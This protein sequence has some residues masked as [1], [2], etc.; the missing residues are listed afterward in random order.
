MK[1]SK[2]IA[3]VMLAAVLALGTG[4][5]G[6]RG[7]GTSAPVQ[8]AEEGMLDLAEEAQ[9]AIIEEENEEGAGKN[10]KKGEKAGKITA[11]CY[12]DFNNISPEKEVQELF[13]TRFGGTVE[14]V[15][16]CNS[17]NYF[18]KLGEMVSTGD[19]PDIVRC[20]WT[21]QYGAFIDGKFEALDD[22]LDI[23]SPVWSDMNDIIESFACGGKHYYFPQELARNYGVTYSSK[24]I[25]DIGEPKDPIDLYLENKW[26]WDDFERMLKEWMDI[27]PVNHIGLAWGE[28]TGLHLAATTGVT[29]VQF[30][31]TDIV[32]NL[33]SPGIAKTM[34]FLEKLV[35]EGYIHDMKSG[36]DGWRSPDNGFS[37][38]RLLFYIMPIDWAISAC[39]TDKKNNNY[40]GEICGVPLPRDPD[41]TTYSILGNTYGYL[42]PA[43]AKNLQGATAWILSG[44]IY[45]NDPEVVKERRELALYDGPYYRPVCTKCKHKFESQM[46]EA[47]EVC[48]ECGEP[49][50]EMAHDTY[51]ERQLKV[52]DDML[53]PSKFTFLFDC[54]RGFGSG[55]N[56]A[57]GDT[58][59][60]L[61]TLIKKV[62][63]NSMDGTDTYTHTL[64]SNYTAIETELDKYR[65]KLKEMNSAS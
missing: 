26:T 23:K 34:Q 45:N 18:E 17:N 40:D 20:E 22:W 15:G 48:P 65:A 41:S 54:H 38:G 43:G 21:M 46:G 49:R 11:L 10:Y 44:R 58:S 13:A 9:N 33:K 19:S 51:T 47:N 57:S 64:E 59:S 39:T 28:S 14:M 31:G 4:A 30:T 27:D 5:C 36:T 12:Y 60:D 3:S 53:D 24:M 7:E 16:K 25:E 32:N 63:D 62:F 35:A 56:E 6:K 2:K 29:A 50:R 61:T 52:L 55:I 42:V 1:R 8:S 37:D